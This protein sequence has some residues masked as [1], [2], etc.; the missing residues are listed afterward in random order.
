MNVDRRAKRKKKTVCR[1]LIM[2]LT[3]IKH[4]RED[5]NFLYEDQRF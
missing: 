3:E 2:V 4:I 1:L 5:F